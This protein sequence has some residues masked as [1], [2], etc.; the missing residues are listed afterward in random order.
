LFH[1]S[2]EWSWLNG[3]PQVIRLEADYD[4][5]SFLLIIVTGAT[6]LDPLTVA[7]NGPITKTCRS[8]AGNIFFHGKRFLAI[9]FV[10]RS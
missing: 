9:V 1:S 6:P 4:Q 7:N 10:L 3:V 2:K 5:H 8:A